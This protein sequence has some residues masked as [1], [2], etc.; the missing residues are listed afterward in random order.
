MT[1]GL[2][3]FVGCGEGN[4]EERI[5]GADPS[6]DTLQDASAGLSQRDI[7]DLAWWA[8]TRPADMESGRGDRGAA[9]GAGR[10]WCPSSRSTST[11]PVS[12]RQGSPRVGAMLDHAAQSGSHPHAGS[13]S[14]PVR[15][16]A[17]RRACPAQGRAAAPQIW[18]PAAGRGAI[19]KVLRAAGHAVLA[20]DLMDYGEPTHFADR[21]F[22]KEPLPRGVECILT[23]PPYRLAEEF[24]GHALE[25]CRASS[26][27]CAGFSKASDAARSSRA[28]GLRACMCSASVCR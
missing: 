12:W 18:E 4:G 1:T 28:A 14:R 23:N 9:A 3:R 24:V 20:S 22:L 15:D 27:C 6:P 21:D 25:L 19:V 7:D 17:L 13:R 16:P 26:C 2:L 11:S 10:A 8:M 5:R